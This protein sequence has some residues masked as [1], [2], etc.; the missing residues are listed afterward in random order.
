MLCELA[1]YSWHIGWA[2]GEDFPLF[3]EKGDEGSRLL[4][5]KVSVHTD[6]FSGSVR[7]TWWVTVSLSMLKSRLYSFD[8]LRLARGK[9]FL[10]VAM[11]IT[12]SSCSAPNVSETL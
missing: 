2:P 9:V 5:R 1:R 4:F 8:S 10:S 6:H 11:A 12:L 7:C 3:T